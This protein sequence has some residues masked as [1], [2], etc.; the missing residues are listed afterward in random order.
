MAYGVQ[1]NG[2][3]QVLSPQFSGADLSIPKSINFQ[4]YLYR[5]GNPMDTTMNMWFG[6]YDALTGGSQLF[7]QTINNVIVTKGWF[8]VSLDNI[9]N[10]VFPV[11]GPTRYLEIKA[12]ATGPALTPRISLVS[13]GYSYHSI[14]AD[15]AEYAKAA[16]LSRPITPPIY[17]D[18][19]RDTTI[20]TAKIK[21]GAITMPKINQ[22]G[23]TTGQVIKWTGNSWAPRNDTTGPPSGP[24][25]GD[26]TGTYPNPT[27]ANNA[28]NSTKIP[29]GSIR[30]ID[31]AKPCTL[32]TSTAFSDAVLYVKNTGDGDAFRVF[33]AGN[34]GVQVDSAGYGYALYRAANDGLWIA[35]A[36]NNGVYIDSAGQAGINI[37]W[38]DYNGVDVDSVEWMGIRVG[39]AR[40]GFG[41]GDAIQDA[42]GVGS[43]G[44][45]GVYIG[46]VGNDGFRVSYTGNDGFSVDSAGRFGLRVESAN[47]DGIRIDSAANDGLE[48][49]KAEW[50][51]YVKQAFSDGVY[52]ENAGRW[53]VRI[54]NAQEDGL[55]VNNAGIC[56]VYV[57]QAG[58]YGVF[59]RSTG[60]VPTAGVYGEGPITTTGAYGVYGYARNN[61]IYGKSNYWEGVFGRS[62]S[63]DA[64]QGYYNGSYST[65]AGVRG[66]RGSAGYGV[67]YVGG[68]GGTGEK[69]TIVKTSKG[70][71]A[72]YSQESPENWFEDFGEGKLN[73]GHCR[74]ELD[75]FFL[76]TVTINDQYPLRVFIQL[77]DNCN[78][79]YVK[80]ENTGFDVYELQSG[81]SNATF[82]YR[83][84]AKRKGYED[85]RLKLEE[86]GYTDGHLYPDPNDPQIPAKIRAKRLEEVDIKKQVESTLHPNRVQAEIEKRRKEERTPKLSIREKK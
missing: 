69:S 37:R 24:A 52:V 2:M 79:V 58:Q 25:G 7:Q 8:T 13:V 17:S 53:G 14:T 60:S 81:T 70:P 1:D 28:V 49:T 68:I 67:Y 33:R 36:G 63:D 42:I 31:I 46:R 71:V 22:S 19:I 73:N 23:A 11:A 51:V 9:P 80:K 3:T 5:D 72:L 18:E 30:G 55:N 41:V 82:T 84:V 48:V 78:G 65:Y 39:K 29:D 62:D 75:K 45:Y 76:E 43:A 35:R 40:F 54:F 20:T 16:P 59:A 85:L 26:L 77:E 34:D 61:G 74:I 83:V 64:V 38:S 50:G 44:N 32:Q 86:I 15:S 21:D 47:E 10:S 66:E 57:N 4:G 6:I 12:P 27:I 56:G